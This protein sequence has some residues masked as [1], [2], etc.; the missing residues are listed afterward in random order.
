MTLTLFHEREDEG[1]VFKVNLLIV[2]SYSTIM[3]ISIC[4]AWEVTLEWVVLNNFRSRGF[5]KQRMIHP[6]G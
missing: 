3:M 2:C 1:H 5:V 6:L 4:S